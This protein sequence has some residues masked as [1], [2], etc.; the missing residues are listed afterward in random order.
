MQ[1]HDPEFAPSVD[2]II[3]QTLPA[4]DRLKREGKIRLVGMTGYP[5]TLQKEIFERAHVR[6]HTIKQP[7]NAAI[8]SSRSN[9]NHAA[10]AS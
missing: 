1:V 9:G 10:S 2:V 7:I 5:L 4:L 3:E 6:D 8:D